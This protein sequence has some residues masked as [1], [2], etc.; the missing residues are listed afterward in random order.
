[1][2]TD[3]KPDFDALPQSSSERRKFKNLFF[4]I[5]CIITAATSV[6]ILISLLTSII[7]GGIHVID[8]DFVFGPP[9][10]EAET[11]G[12]GP[13]LSGTIWVCAICACVA[14]PLGVST[15]IF[16][17]EYKPSNSVFLKL[18]QF[19]QLNISNLAGV[20]SIVYGLLGLTAFALMYDMLGTEN[21][22]SFEFGA[23]H[24][25]Q[26]LT[27]GT[28]IVFVPVESREAIP[29]LKDGMLAE[30]SG[31]EV[32]L[33]IIDEGDEYPS[34]E[35]L[36]TSLF[37]GDPGSQLTRNAWYYFR[38]PFGRSVLTAGLTLMLVVL[39][40]V[41]I[42]SQESLR[43][44][45]SSLREGA[46]GLGATRW[47]VI[48][49]VTLPAA[50]PGI[51]TGSILSTSRAIGEAA[52]LVILAG[53]IYKTESP[54]HLMDQYSVLPLQI[55]YWASQPTDENAV[56]NF[57]SI[58]AGGSIVLLVILLTFNAVAIALRQIMSKPLT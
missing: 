4:K 54:A 16:L 31:R 52:P 45:P 39:P 23:S 11:S 1:M 51:M 46:L 13:A 24:Y 36:V 49:N 18:H 53:L 48:R 25:R 19:I 43:S 47:Q 29:E 58:A 50:V 37:A 30:M 28:G 2:A 33:N 27:E 6:V 21:K 12:I 41:I 32:K 8:K 10:A 38:L 14:L 42:A 56:V 20:P 40:I 34:G 22:P 5:I 17:E 7:S 3:N 55:F 35:L 26:Y 57:Q 15:A 44:V 9:S